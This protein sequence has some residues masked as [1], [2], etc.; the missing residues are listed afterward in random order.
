MGTDAVAHRNTGDSGR[1]EFASIAV[2]LIQER[3][4]WGGGSRAFFFDSFAKWNP[5]ELWIGSGDIQYVHNEYLQAAVDYGLVGL[6]LLLGVFAIVM[7]RGVALLTVGSRELQGEAG[8][9]LGSIAALCA[10]GVQA[11]F[12][13]VYHVLPDVILMGCCI[14]WLVRQPWVLSAPRQAQP[15]SRL[16]LWWRGLCG[17]GIA[18]VVVIFAARDAAAWWSLYPRFDYAKAENLEYEKRYRK[19]VHLRQDFR[20][21]SAYAVVLTN[22]ARDEKSTLEELNAYLQLAIGWQ[23]ETL[24][25]APVSYKDIVNM[26]LLYD[27]VGRLDE[28]EALFQQ[29][30]PALGAREMYYGTRYFYARHLSL[31][32]NA[33]W[34][35]RQPEKALLLFLRAKDELSRLPAIYKNTDPMVRR[36]IEQSIEFLKSANIEPAASEDEE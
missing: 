11:F 1:L 16:A 8:I 23:E 35:Q 30:L 28:A 3:P 6:V 10:M 14:G 36:S 7:F 15:L 32:A 5:K 25:R 4:L 2:D 34:R 19:A 21:M 17:S 20:L 13:F 31:R 18:V 27:S 29:V 9:A 33:V 12:S 24:K 26:A 22:L